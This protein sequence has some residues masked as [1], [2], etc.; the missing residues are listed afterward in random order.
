[1][2]TGNKQMKFRAEEPLVEKIERAA[3]GAGVSV[4]EWLRLAAVAQL[5][6]MTAR[7]AIDAMGEV[8]RRIDSGKTPPKNPHVAA[9]MARQQLHDGTVREVP[10]EHPESID[11]PP[12][13][14]RHDHR[15]K[16]PHGTVACQDCPA[17][18]VNGRWVIVRA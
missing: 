15:V 5:G 1:M 8:V 3:A 16:G 4:A 12:E 10:I 11:A 18:L 2:P 14:C 6:Q 13:H 9:R 7:E 17:T